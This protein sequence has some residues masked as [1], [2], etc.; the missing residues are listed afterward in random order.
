MKMKTRLGTVLVVMLLVALPAGAAEHSGGFLAIDTFGALFMGPTVEAGYLSP[1]GWTL[2]VNVRSMGT[3]LIYR[4][5][6]ESLGQWP[7]LATF[8]A[9]FD[10][11]KS[12]RLGK[13]PFEPYIGLGVEPALAVTKGDVGTPVEWRSEAVGVVTMATI[14]SSFWLGD[15]AF[16]DCGF[17]GGVYVIL[18]SAW[19]YTTYP[20]GVT[21]SY[22][23][24]TFF[25][26]SGDLSLGFLLGR[27]R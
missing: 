12:F 25:A 16:L 4:L 14:G 18:A 13:L 22:P 20:A 5:V 24:T 8:S 11:S 26:G 1:R 6:V 23:L 21:W 15:R 7:D 9:G 17:S 2:G 27:R 10:V 19:Y 3:G